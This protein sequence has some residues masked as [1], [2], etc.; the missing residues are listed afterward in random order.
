[1]VGPPRISISPQLR[2]TAPGTRRSSAS[3]AGNSGDPLQRSSAPRSS[4]DSITVTV[5]FDDTA[6]I[7]SISTV[8]GGTRNVPDRPASNPLKA[9]A[10]RLNGCAG[11]ISRLIPITRTR[12][13]LPPIVHQPVSPSGP[14]RSSHPNRRLFSGRGS[15]VPSD[16]FEY[17]PFAS[18]NAANTRRPGV[19]WLNRTRIDR[20][21][22]SSGNGIPGMSSTRICSNRERNGPVYRSGLDH[23]TSAKVSGSTAIIR[24]AS[25]PRVRFTAPSRRITRDT[26][27]TPSISSIAPTMSA[28]GLRGL[29][30]SPITRTSAPVS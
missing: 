19:G 12:S 14:G 28:L 10:R 2:L 7:S 20:Y 21:R 26:V 1:M 22:V 6:E 16:P 18:L 27:M 15:S 4:K 5:P 13:A 11:A 24:N 30:A 3:A 29:G 25:E 8:P 17:L 23:A 9:M